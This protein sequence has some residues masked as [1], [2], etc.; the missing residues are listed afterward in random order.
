MKIETIK[1]RQQIEQNR[2]RE[3]ILQVLD[4]LETDSSELA[5]RNAL[6]A[7]DA[8]Y[9]EAHRTQVTLE[10]VLPDGESLEAVLDEWRELCKE[11]FTTRTRADTFLKEKDESKEPMATPALTEKSGSKLQLGK[12]KPVPLPKFDGNI[13]E[14]KS[15]WDQFEVNIDRR[16]DIGAI[17]KNHGLRGELPWSRSDAPQS[18][19]SSARGG[20]SH[21]LKVVNLKECS[22]DGAADLT[23]LHDDLNRH[24]LELRALGK[25]VDA[26]LSGFHALLPI[27]KKKLPPDTLEA[28]RAFVQGMTNEKITSSVFLSFLLNQS[29]IKGPARKMPARK[30]ERRSEPGERF[31]TATIQ[32]DPVGNCV[33]CCGIHPVE[34][35]LRFVELSGPERW[36]CVRKHGLCFGCLRKGHRIGSCQQ[37]PDRLGQH[38]LLG[39]LREPPPS[40][41]PQTNQ[42]ARPDAAVKEKN[43][44]TAPAQGLEAEDT[45]FDRAATELAPVGVHFSSTVRAPGVLLPVVQAMAYGENGKKRLVNCLLDSASEK[46]LIRTDVADEL[47]LSGTPNAVTVRGVHGL[48]ARVA[49]SR[50]VR[51]QLGQANEETAVSTK[52]ELTALCI[53]NIC[54]DLI[55]TPLPWPRE[56]DLPRAATLATPPCLTSIHVLI[57]FDMYY[58]VLGRGLRIAGEDDPIAM[59]TIFGWILCGPKARSP[60]GKQDT[61]MVSTVTESSSA[62]ATEELNL[63][64]RRFWEIDSI[65][66][67]QEVETNTD[68]DVKRKFSESVT[69]D[70]KRY[71]VGLLWRA[72]A[73]QL[74][75]NREV[76]MRRLRALRRQLNRDPEKDQEY[77]G[78]IRDYLDRGWAEKVDGTSGPPGRTWYLPHHAVYQHNQGKTKCRVVFDGSAEWNGTSLN[79][80]L[81]P[82]PK[83]QPDLV[84]VLLRFRRS[85]IALQADIEKMYLQVGLRREDRD[86]CRFLWQERDCGAPVKVYRLTRVGFG[87]TCSPFLAMQVVRH[88]AQSCGNIDELTDRVL[89]DMYVDDL[90]TSCDGVDE[91]RRLVQR[92]TEL[93]KTGGFVLKKWASNDSDALMDLPAEDVSSADKDRLWKTL[94]LHWNRHSDHLTFMPMPDIHPERHDSKR[95]LLSLASRLF[96]PLGCLAPFTIRAKKMFQS[97]WLKGLD[98]DDQLPLDISSVWCQWK[99]ELE[100]LDSVRVPRA[101]MVIPKGQVRRLELHVFGD[102]SETAFGAVAYLMTESMDRTKEVRFCLAK[103]R[104]AP[105]KR[106]SLPRLE[107]M[108]ALHVARLKEYVERELG[109]P[110]NRSTCWSDSTIVLSWI[111]GDPRRWKPFVANRVQ[112]I[113]SR[114]EPSQWRHC[115]TADNPAD[116]LSRG[117]ALNT[118]REDNLWWNGPAWLREPIEQWP[119]RTMSLSPEE[120]RLVSPERK[121]VVT[122]CASLQEP[123]L[124]AIIDPSRYGTME[125][126]VRITA[127]CCRFLANAR[128][129]AGERKIGARL[130][131]Q[132]LQDAEKRWVR[133]VQADAFSVSKTA[134]GPIPV[135]AG[136]PLAALSPFVDTEGLL[137][138]GGRLSRTALPW[139][140]RHPLL[141]PRNDPVV[142][143]IVRR[144]HESELHAGLNQTLAAL[145]RRFW[146]RVEIQHRP[147]S[148]VRWLLGAACQ[149][150]EERSEEGLGEGV[151]PQ[152]GV[153]HSAVIGITPDSRCVRI[154]PDERIQLAKALVP[155]AAAD[156]TSVESMAGRVSSDSH[157][158][159]EMD[160]DRAAAG[161]GRPSVPSGRRRSTETLE[162]RRD[163]R[164]VDG[165]RWGH[166]VGEST[167]CPRPSHPA[168]QI[169]NSS[170]ASIGSVMNCGPSPR[171]GDC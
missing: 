128:T 155:P 7:L 92:L 108:A 21:V 132:E 49:D 42:A 61:T 69:F 23:R 121:R 102:A 145:R 100:T 73:V 151:T 150:D 55:A 58:R 140:H 136:D 162:T 90:A 18:I 4:Q 124:L 127:Y 52:L 78:V 66:V 130:S 170:R 116:K 16:E 72:G 2:L 24:F 86:V 88:H 65:G 50:Q 139:C 164:A 109:L 26:N 158:T 31:M 97:L 60:A 17:T 94:G 171:G 41:E 104:V 9:A 146:D 125:R 74:P 44:T 63:L 56:I 54:D 1:R 134:S 96:D 159:R 161:K 3:T 120:T 6:R 103:T 81:D 48:S 106:L 22:D 135:R 83:L 25:D 15:F 166:E 43:P 87:L 77:S 12:L 156:K 114:T 117:C 119:R 99:R 169:A 165:K 101:L 64:L 38:P 57:G 168:E 45:A 46:S 32:V 10:D 39:Q 147:S 76:A 148:L 36:Q 27:I 75:D 89:S 115:P 19:P 163:H 123:S 68:E 110:F 82:G 149:I 14:F 34:S 95:E 157:L 30:P 20:E 40:S 167:D 138:V 35:C 33:V 47:E 113:L 8:Q 84:A 70:G 37:N 85:R 53:P 133:A 105:V 126:L 141:L 122:L 71:V 98:W 67:V 80:C 79:N 107:L 152:L 137:R 144:T 11:V 142:E 13:L 111:Q 143:L 112:E 93:M 131:L 5:V 91:A 62:G 28:W 154:S 29:R 129:H 153:A 59:E 118:L 160:E 51:F